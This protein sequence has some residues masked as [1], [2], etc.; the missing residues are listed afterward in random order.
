M[1]NDI[2]FINKNKIFPHILHASVSIFQIQICVVSGTFVYWF[3][4]KL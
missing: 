3:D 4:P 1:N 2:K